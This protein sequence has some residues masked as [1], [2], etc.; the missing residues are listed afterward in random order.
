MD[1]DNNPKVQDNSAIAPSSDKVTN[2]AR[3]FLTGPN[4]HHRGGSAGLA[5]PGAAGG[6]S[7]L[8]YKKT[9]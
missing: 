4:H 2:S 3:M 1:G 8:T 6:R 5:V 9:F 7:S